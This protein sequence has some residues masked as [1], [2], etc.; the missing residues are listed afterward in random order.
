MVRHVRR[1]AEPLQFEFED[2]GLG[3]VRVEV[4]DDEHLVRAV[5]GGLGEGDDLIV[6]HLLEAQVGVALERLVLAAA[7]IEAGDQAAQ[8]VRPLNVPLLDLVLLRVVVLF[9]AGIRIVFAE[10]IL[11]P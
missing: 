1:D 9:L 7:G 6:V 2:A 8:A 5:V 3:V 10:L 11:T 4:D